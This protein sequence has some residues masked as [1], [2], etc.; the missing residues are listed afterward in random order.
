LYENL[1]V[2]EHLEMVSDLKGVM[3]KKAEVDDIL[4]VTLLTRH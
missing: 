4:K 1:S 2:R 3:D